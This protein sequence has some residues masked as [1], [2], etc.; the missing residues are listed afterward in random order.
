MAVHIE[1]IDGKHEAAVQGFAVDPRISATT[2]LPY[3]YPEGAAREWIDKSLDSRAK[4]LVYEYAVMD[5]QELVGVCGI[6]NISQGEGEIGYWTGTPHWGKGYASFAVSRLLEQGFTEL[7]LNRLYAKS[8]VVNRAS[9][10]VLEKAGF[11]LTEVN[12]LPDSKW[13][14]EPVAIFEQRVEMWRV[15]QGI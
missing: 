14:G 11:H 4:G 2:T 8:L 3:P 1:L 7:S 6:L 10:R 13:P 5:G 12:E 15:G 9:C